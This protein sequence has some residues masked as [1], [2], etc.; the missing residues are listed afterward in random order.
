MIQMPYFKLIILTL[1]LT[2]GIDALEAVLLNA[3]AGMFKGSTNINA[4][5]CVVGSR[6]LYDGIIAIVAGL[7]APF[8]LTGSA[9]VLA[10]GG[11]I[12]PYVQYGA[13]R[14]V[15]QG[16]DDRRVYAF[17]IV[18]VISALVLYVIFY[19]MAADMLTS[20]IGSAMSGLGS[21][22]GSGFGSYY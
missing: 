17:F 9:F 22:F 4:M 13:Y 20:M 6:A 5:F 1:L 16:D 10:F 19:L 15:A 14:S 8:F 21:G 11:L 7:L 12:L 2:V 18:K 3:F